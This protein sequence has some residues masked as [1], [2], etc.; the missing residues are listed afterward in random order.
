MRIVDF[1]S[2]S[3]LQ[4]PPFVTSDQKYIM[5]QTSPTDAAQEPCPEKSPLFFLAA[6]LT[7]TNA[8]ETEKLRECATALARDKSHLVAVDS[9]LESGTC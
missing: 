4:K 3:V 2:S 6:K 1:Y 9:E 8:D 5:S 7:E